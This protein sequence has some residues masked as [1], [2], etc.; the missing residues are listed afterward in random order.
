VRRSNITIKPRRQLP[1]GLSAELSL[2]EHNIEPGRALTRWGDPGWAK[3][4]RQGKYDNHLFSEDLVDATVGMIRAWRP[5]PP[6]TWITSVPSTSSGGLVRDFA[7]RVA[8]RLSLPLVAAVHRV[9]ERPPQKTLENSCL[10]A[11]NVLGAFEVSRIRTGPVL[12]IDDMV[13][14]GWTF[15]MIGHQLRSAGSGLVYPVALA[16]T[17]GGNR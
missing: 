11:R 7:Q 5:D 3:L 15:T 1:C 16:D 17:S 6:P 13:D 12:L 9:D 4:V 2:K 10:Q 8:D 14:S